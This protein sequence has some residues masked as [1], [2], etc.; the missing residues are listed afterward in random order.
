MDVVPD[1]DQHSTSIGNRC[2]PISYTKCNDYVKSSSDLA[3]K[4]V[5][6]SCEK[7]NIL[8]CIQ[9]CSKSKD[10]KATAA[11]K[12]LY[13]NPKTYSGTETSEEV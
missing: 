3:G 10:C 2:Y 11:V 12:F 6:F 1:Y 13:G 7:S 8:G 4:K 9:E 5:I